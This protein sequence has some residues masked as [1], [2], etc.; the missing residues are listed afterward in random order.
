MLLSEM[1]ACNDLNNRHI[2]HSGITLQER[3][4]AHCITYCQVKS[5]SHHRVAEQCDEGEL[6][7]QRMTSITIPAF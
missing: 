6:K 2:H 4:R 5:V 3:H 7:L 1:D